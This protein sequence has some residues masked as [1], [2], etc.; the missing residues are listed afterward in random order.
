MS[1]VVG[2]NDKLCSTI[3]ETYNDSVIAIKVVAKEGVDN[4]EVGESCVFYGEYTVG[5]NG[6]VNFFVRIEIL[7]GLKQQRIVFQDRL[8]D[9]DLLTFDNIAIWR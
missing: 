1:D 7:V 8:F 5:P 4:F 6:F 2:T 3:L 9:D